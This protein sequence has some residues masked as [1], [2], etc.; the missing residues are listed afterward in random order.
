MRAASGSLVGKA[1]VSAVELD[2]GVAGEMVD[3]GVALV[4]ETTVD[5][6]VLGT[7]G[8]L[9]GVELGVDVC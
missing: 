8:V 5:P 7:V 6:A 4:S 3:I 1:A 2:I 9:V